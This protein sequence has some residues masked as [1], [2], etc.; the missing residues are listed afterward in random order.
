MRQAAVCLLDRNPE[1]N[2]GVHSTLA[3]TKQPESHH[4]EMDKPQMRNALLKKTLEW[5]VSTLSN[6]Q[7]HRQGNWSRLNETK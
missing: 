3:R 7:W 4:E 6:C 5:K 1:T 2:T